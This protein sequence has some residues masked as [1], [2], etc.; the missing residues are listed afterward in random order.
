MSNI[1]TLLKKIS[2][3]RKDLLNHKIYLKLNSEDAIAKFMETHVFAVWDFMSLVKALQKEL[4]CVN[5]PWTPTKDKIS[6]RL[7]NEIVLGEESDID[8]NNNPISHFELYLEA[9]NRIGAETDSIG[10][11]I[12][13]LF[14]LGDIDRAIDKSSIPEAAKDFMRF[15]FDIINKKEVHVI[16]SVF[17]FG[18]E[19]LIP[20]MFIN[21]VKTL[22]DKEESKSD[23]LLYYLERHIEMDGDEHGPMAL[24][25]ISEL[26]GNDANKWN[27]AAK[28]SKM[29]LEKRIK[30]WDSIL[31][32]ISMK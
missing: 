17:T 1:D 14:E 31:H 26:C 7:I 11:F 16:A 18:R 32:E 13:N 6:R 5:T 2:R 24:K 30:L 28:Y 22:N 19:D 3:T 9:M 29:A 10:I 15:T 12:N 25:M 20:D 27:E 8:Q 21:I 4:T 23:D